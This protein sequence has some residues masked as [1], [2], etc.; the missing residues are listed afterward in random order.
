MRK[1]PEL[2][3]FDMDGLLFD[4]ERLFMNRKNKILTEYGYPARQEDYVQTIGLSG[5]QLREKLAELYGSEY[6]A[7]EISRK[8]RA[9]VNTCLE[10]HGPDVKPGIREL[11]YWLREREIPCCVASSTR[12]DYVEKYLQLADLDDCFSF[13]IGGEEVIRSKPEPD[14]FLAACKKAVVRPEDA[15]VLE[16]S[17]NGVRAAFAAGIPVI[18][19]PDLVYPSPEVAAM[20]EA[21]VSSAGEVVRKLCG[22][23]EK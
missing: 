15:F 1:L 20:A 13:V 22:M 8:T 2:M 23:S 9:M 5:N 17:E 3:I 16:D 14:I 21:V 7:D 18:C 10:E 6:P 4:T 12:H 11:L 19:I